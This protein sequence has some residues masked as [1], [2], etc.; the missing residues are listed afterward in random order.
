MSFNYLA[1]KIIFP[2]EIFFGIILADAKEYHRTKDD[3]NP[4]SPD[5]LFIASITN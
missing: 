2:K 4:I 3:N 1:E 5:I